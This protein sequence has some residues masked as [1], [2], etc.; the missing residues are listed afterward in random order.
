MGYASQQGRARVSARSPQAAGVCDRCSFIYTHSTLRWQF[1]Y[2]GAGLINKRILVCRTCED[3]PQNQLRS[4]VVPAD[5]V[6]IQNPRV[7]NYVQAASNTRVTSG[8]DTIDPT[9][10][11]PVPGGDVRIT[12]DDNTRVTQQTGAS[13]GSLNREPG[14]DPNVPGPINVPPDNVDVPNTGPL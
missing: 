6:P 14:T 11:I 12:E 10:G 1:D 13:P 3:L 8:Q 2:A 4:I 9:T 5:P 7:P